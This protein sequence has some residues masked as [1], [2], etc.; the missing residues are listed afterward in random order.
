[1]T[2]MW[3]NWNIATYA[4]AFKYKNMY[5]ALIRVIYIFILQFN[6]AKNKEIVFLLEVSYS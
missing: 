4:S 1:M 5:D 6:K 2:L 3:L